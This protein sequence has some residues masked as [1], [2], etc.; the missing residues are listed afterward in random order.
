MALTTDL[1]FCAIAL[2]TFNFL[3]VKIVFGGRGTN[4]RGLDVLT[5]SKMNRKSNV[6]DIFQHLRI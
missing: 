1:F 4:F 6:T 5:F 3:K 2:E